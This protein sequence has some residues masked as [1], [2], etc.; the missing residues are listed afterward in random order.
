VDF[1]ETPDSVCVGRA[2]G[3]GLAAYGDV[4]VKAVMNLLQAELVRIMLL[5]GAA[6]LDAITRN[7]VRTDSSG[8]P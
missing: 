7:H 4:G 6:N 5:A 2:Y 1:R 8:P 3:Y